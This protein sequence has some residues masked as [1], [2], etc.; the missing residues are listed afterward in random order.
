LA[1][2]VSRDL[3]G[4]PD[5]MRGNEVVLLDEGLEQTAKPGGVYAIPIAPIE[6]FVIRS[7]ER[8]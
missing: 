8:R 4:L 6:D 3:T 1:S 7:E 5:L 2:S